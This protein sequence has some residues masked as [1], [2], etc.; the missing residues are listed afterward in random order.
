[1]NEIIK[2]I[3]NA[4]KI[5]KAT[6][7]YELGVTPTALSRWC[8]EKSLPKNKTWLKIKEDWK[9]VLASNSN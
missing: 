9:N 5:S 2:D 3:C 7:A 6:Y 8:T 1:M 4:R